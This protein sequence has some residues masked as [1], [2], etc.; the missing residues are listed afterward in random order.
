MKKKFGIIGRP[1][2]HSLSPVLHN[3]W[4]K[5]YGLNASYTTI[6]AE[7]KDLEDVIKK[8]REH[9]LAG[10]NVTLPFKQKIINQTD[11]IINDAELTGSVNT[12]LLDN[13]KIIGENTDVFGL[14]AAYLKEIDDCAFKN[15]LVIGAGG[16]SPSVILSLQKSGVKKISITNRTSEKCIFLKKKFNFLNLLPWENLK[17][18]IKNFDII[19]NAT[20]L[21]LKNGDNFNFNFANTKKELI[22]IDT[23][24]NP[25]ETKT[26]KFLKEEG[27]KVFNGLDMFIYQGQKSFYLWTKINPEIDNGL[28]DLLNSKLK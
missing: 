21:G 15:T 2:K 16:V 14:Q 27:K 4:F 17:D 19:I 13:D 3:Y 28:I 8:I 1:I 18:E 25:L 11:K 12:I 10:I 22:Y 9:E 20:S 5:K 24:Y 26:Y 23:I 6:E 7:D